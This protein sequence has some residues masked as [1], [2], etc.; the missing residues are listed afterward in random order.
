M[1]SA[2]EW[3]NELGKCFVYIGLRCPEIAPENAMVNTT[4]TAYGSVVKVYCG[5]GHL[6]GGRREVD[7]VCQ[8]NGKWS[9]WPIH[10]QRKYQHTYNTYI[11]QTNYLSGVQ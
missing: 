1:E 4:D 7:V 3:H 10:C 11:V 2:I 8:A 9:L 6:Y 5:A